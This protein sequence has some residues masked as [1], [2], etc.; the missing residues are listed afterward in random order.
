LKNRSARLS[1]FWLGERPSRQPVAGMRVTIVDAEDMFTAMLAHQLA[2][3]GAVARIRRWSDPL[4]VAGDVLVLG[5]GPGDP[6]DAADSKMSALRRWLATAAGH[7]PV[8]GL[9]LGHQI[10]AAGLGLAVEARAEPNQG[11][12][13]VVD[14]FG[15]PQRV[16]F[17]NTFTA[18]SH[19]DAIT[20]PDWGTVQLARDRATGEVHALR[21]RRLGSFQF[22]PESVLTAAG[23]DLL[24]A[25]L[26]RLTVPVTTRTAVT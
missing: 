18:R 2:A 19:A 14:L 24:A 25:E 1:S 3:I 9:C 20:A 23:P 16:G 21:A 4:D 13:R 26:R 11:T 15:T 10:I 6:T 7:M 5:P 17:Y 8:L 12:Q 22:H